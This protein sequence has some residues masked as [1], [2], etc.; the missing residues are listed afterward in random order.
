MRLSE[1][2]YERKKIESS[3]LKLMNYRN[4]IYNKKFPDTEKETLDKKEKRYNDFLAKCAKEIIKINN[5]IDSHISDYTKLAHKINEKNIESEI[6]QKLLTM[7]F[8]RLELASLNKLREEKY[9]ISLDV[10]K[11]KETG[12]EKRL[13]KIEE[14]KRKLDCS[15]EHLNYTNN[16]ML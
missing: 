15:I 11:I 8:I 12:I 10:E 7:K 16:I 13:E 3:I 9:F 2:L 4:A 6:D 14:E 1:A 5:E